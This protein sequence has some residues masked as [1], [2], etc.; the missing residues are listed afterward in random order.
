MT[1]TPYMSML[2]PDPSIT[3][4]PTWATELVA[5]MNV[6]DAHNHSSGSGVLVPVAGLNINADLPLGNVYNLTQARSLRMYNNPAVLTGATDLGILCQVG[7]ELYYRDASGNQIQITASGALNAASIGGIGGDYATSTASLAYSSASKT[8]TFL[9]AALT[10]ALIDCGPVTIRL[11]SASS[12]GIKLTPAA[13][14]AGDYTLT[15]PAAL[16]GSTLLLQADVSGN[17]SWSNTVASLAVTAGVTIGT[18]LGVSG[19]STL[20]SLAVTAGAT[21]GTTLAVGTTLGVT[22]K[23]TLTG[24]AYAAAG[25][26]SDNSSFI[27]MK[28][29]TGTSDGTGKMEIAHGLTSSKILGIIG[30]ILSSDGVLYTELYL[31]GSVDCDKMWNGTI[32]RIMIHHSDFYSRPGKILIFYTP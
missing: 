27:K 30:Y 31:S 16:P 19:L 24:G 2:L 32:V 8:F 18:T 10:P 5:A 6:V 11:A 3:L 4:G 13:G 9:Q 28:V 12:Y 15:L 23:S 17:I 25:F 14:I 29:V 22:G 21:V 26:S 7:G 1:T 20:A